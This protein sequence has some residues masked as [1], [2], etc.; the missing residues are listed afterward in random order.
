[1]RY[2]LIT[3]DDDKY[4]RETLPKITAALAKFKVRFVQSVTFDGNTIK[5]NVKADV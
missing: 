2:I 4:N 5:E 1:M 3:I